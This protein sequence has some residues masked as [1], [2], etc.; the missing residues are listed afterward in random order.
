MSAS[1]PSLLRASVA[2]ASLLALWPL[3]AAAAPVPGPLSAGVGGTVPGPAQVAPLKHLPAGPGELVFRGESA[4]RSWSVYLGRG[5]I[6]RTR[7]FQLALKNAVSVLP[8][9]SAVRL[10]IN[11]RVLATLQARSP[12]GLAVL[13]VAIPSGL[14][15]PG[16]NKV[17]ISVVMTHRV[18]CSL[19]ATYELWTLVDPAKTGFMAP[20]VPMSALRSI[21]DIAGEPLAE[22]GTTRIHL[23]AASL[24]DA[25]GIGRAGRFIAALVSRAGLARPVV[26]AG[27]AAGQGAGFDVLLTTTGAHDDVTR[28]LKILGREDDVAFARDPATDRLVLI[29]SGTDDADLDRRVAAFAGKATRPPAAAA[30]GEMTVE[31]ETRRSFSDLGLPT[32]A[33]AGRHY[34]QALDV[35]LP[36]DFYPANYDRAQMLID[37]SYAANLDPDSDIVFR[38]NG[39]LVSS[40]RLG[41]NRGGVLQHEMVELPL[42]FFHPGHNAIALEANTTTPADRQC[43]TAAMQRDV[44]FTLAGT[45]EIVFPRFAHLGTVPQIPGAMA[46]TAAGQERGAIDLYLAQNDAASVGTGLTVLANM[47]GTRRTGLAPIVHLEAPRGEDAPGLVVGP[48]DAL[49]AAL[50]AP[51]RA[52]MATPAPDG[53]KVVQASTDA[54]PD[55]GRFDW[56]RLVAEARRGLKNQGFFFGS[57]QDAQAVPFSTH[58]LLIAAI[59]PRPVDRKLAGMDVPH[60][61][62][63]TAQWLVVTASE[64]TTLREGLRRLVAD[65]QWGGLEGRAV[66]LDVESGRLASVQPS[67][68]LYVV[69]DRLVLSDIR[70]ILGGIVSNH[71]ELSLV[72]LVLLMAL[73]GVSTHVLI[74]RAGMK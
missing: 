56:R 23:R 32:D 8:D 59:D 19:A 40:L 54:S 29:V 48:Y 1:K 17:D 72:V 34:T 25:A 27:P 63:D 12:N 3:S 26:D 14:L 42:R 60:F 6:E 65:G 7:G 47:A 13:P 35:V 53:A 55:A 10:S 43:D 46:G 31:N 74:R 2:A 22:D 61:T 16:L 73:L 15:V 62:T 64:G 67:R 58:S 28:T 52:L 36:S 4:H 24:D 37:G 44:R 11:G 30:V 38:V 49:P 68:V 21:E 70:P 45:S 69:P 41:P 50:A 39:A 18:D 66:S 20:A 5:E 71:I 9:R 57:D 51:V 33:F